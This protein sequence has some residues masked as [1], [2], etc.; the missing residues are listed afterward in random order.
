MQ[1][2]VVI[3]TYNNAEGL[4]NALHSILAAKAPEDAAYEVIVVDNNSS[5]YTK[6]T[7]ES[8]SPLFGGNIRYFCEPAQG[9]SC[10]RN[11]G[12]KE[13]KGEFLAFIDDDVQVDALWL[14]E[15]VKNLRDRDVDCIAGRVLPK[16]EIQRPPW[17]TDN[18]CKALGLLDYGDTPFRI[19]SLLH[20]FITANCVIRRSIFNDEAYLFKTCLGHKGTNTQGG[21]DTEVFFSMM[22]GGHTVW[23]CPSCVVYH[24][25]PRKR[26]LVRHFLK[27]NYQNSESKV[28]LTR[29]FP[30][31]YD[32]RELR[33]RMFKKAVD[34]LKRIDKSYIE[35]LGGLFFFAGLLYHN[36]LWHIRKRK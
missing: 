17:I 35:L 7:V 33:R 2:S 31:I 10:A 1:I 16:W 26:M 25:I 21:E 5:D 3:P 15:I 30:G 18:L 27:W 20:E 14:I 22:K 32:G 36:L 9:S 28:F 11:R 24:T 29:M 8:V 12:I 4:H 6:E 23:Y 13:A 19:I 34:C